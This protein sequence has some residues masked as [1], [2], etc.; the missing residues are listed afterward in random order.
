MTNTEKLRALMNAHK[1]STAQVAAILHRTPGTVRVWRC[2]HPA[3]Q[4]P[5]Q[6]LRLLEL[7]LTSRS[8]AGA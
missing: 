4:I 5:D 1:V 6:A 2:K 8:K 3:R 7:E